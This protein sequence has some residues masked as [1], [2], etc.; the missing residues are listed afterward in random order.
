MLD[1]WARIFLF[2][3]PHA[4]KS[5]NAQGIQENRSSDVPPV[6]TSTNEDIVASEAR[7]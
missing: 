1:S 3:V 6:P 7:G 4:S 5:S 2:R